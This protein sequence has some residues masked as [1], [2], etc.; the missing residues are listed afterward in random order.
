MQKDRCVCFDT[1]RPARYNL[2]KE[3]AMTVRPAVPSDLPEVL[4]LLAVLEADLG[5]DDKLDAANAAAM[6]ARMHASPEHYANFV[7]EQDG[8]VVGVVTMAF[9]ETLIHRKGTALINELVVDRDAR[10]TGT[11]AALVER[12]FGEARTRG[13]DEINVG[14]LERNVRA[15]EFYRR[16][17]FDT[18]HVLLEKELD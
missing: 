5:F 8:R 18:R 12:C 17:G 4:R 6:F 10:G 7:A 14:V 9:F 2:P 11:G 3:S 15:Q 13:Y 1:I 16:C